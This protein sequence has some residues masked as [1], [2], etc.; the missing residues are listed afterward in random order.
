M[1]TEQLQ[2]LSIWAVERDN[3]AAAISQLKTEK[4]TVSREVDS[5]TSTKSELVKELGI[6]QNRIDVIKEAEEQLKTVVNKELSE[7]KV[8]LSGLQSNIAASKTQEAE[9]LT[10]V[11]TLTETLNSLSA[12]TEVFRREYIA[13]QSAIEGV[14]NE[15]SLLVPS[16][17]SGLSETSKQ[18]SGISKDIKE[19]VVFL[20]NA[21]KSAEKHS[22]VMKAQRHALMNK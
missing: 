13:L 9:L 10:R 17:N 7:L 1:T 14:K 12:A 22:N 5:L 11:S 21:R 4:E 15:I 2:Q 3:A 18:S 19:V 16:I 20:A 6:I 8:E